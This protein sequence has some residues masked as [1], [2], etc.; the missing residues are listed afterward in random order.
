MSEAQSERL[1]TA[2]AAAGAVSLA[3]RARTGEF[4]SLSGI[5]ENPKSV[6]VGEIRAVAARRRTYRLPSLQ[7]ESLEQRVKD[8]EFDGVPPRSGG[9]I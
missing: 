1:A 9:T 7:F 6:L 8:G 4:S 2:L 5:H 3:M